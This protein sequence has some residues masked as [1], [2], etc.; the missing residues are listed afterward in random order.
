MYVVVVN[1]NS[2][3][4]GLNHC[5]KKSNSRLNDPFSLESHLKC[6]N[7][8]RRAVAVEATNRIFQRGSQRIA[9]KNCFCLLQGNGQ[10]SQAFSKLMNPMATSTSCAFANWKG[11]LRADQKYGR[12]N[13]AGHK[14]AEGSCFKWKK[15]WSMLV[16]F[17]WRL[18][19]APVWN[20]FWFFHPIGCVTPGAE[21]VFHVSKGPFVHQ[22]FGKLGSAGLLRAL[23]NSWQRLKASLGLDAGKHSWRPA[24]AMIR[25]E[26]FRPIFFDR[27]CWKAPASQGFSL[28]QT[29][30]ATSFAAN[31]SKAFSSSSYYTPSFQTSYLRLALLDL[32]SYPI[33]DM[34]SYCDIPLESPS[35][36]QSKRLQGLQGV[37]STL[38]LQ[39]GIWSTSRALCW[40]RYQPTHPKSI[41]PTC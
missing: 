29:E 15:L 40:T 32:F 6:P 9:N 17:N 35:L 18:V 8:V 5:N 34:C 16:L 14:S 2:C 19:T 36:S 39:I 28:R 1:V 13:A 38:C 25:C 21:G 22:K 26:T 27:K 23:W 12:L 7:S 31:G 33:Y 11:I 41:L 30:N 24:N 37:C 20:S 4:W 10:N 3:L